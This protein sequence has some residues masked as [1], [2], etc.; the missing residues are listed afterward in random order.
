MSHVKKTMIQPIHLTFRFLQH[1]TRLQIWLHE[2]SDQRIEGILVGFDEFMNLILDEAVE[3][4]IP[5]GE[6]GG[7][8]S[9][10]PLGRILLKGENVSMI[11]PAPSELVN[12]Q[13]PPDAPMVN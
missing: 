7:P 3:I 2:R 11:G 4:R 12:Q 13:P 1:N 8:E 5:R 9:S 10:T 6:N